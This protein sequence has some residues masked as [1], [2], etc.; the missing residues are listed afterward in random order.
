MSKLKFDDR[1]RV[2]A[3]DLHHLA[4]GRPDQTLEVFLDTQQGRALLTALAEAG[5][6]PNALSSW[7]GRD[8]DLYIHGSLAIAYAHWIGPTFFLSVVPHIKNTPRVGSNEC[9]TYYKAM[10]TVADRMGIKAQAM[11][12]VLKEVAKEERTLA[13]DYGAF[14]QEANAIESAIA[15]GALTLEAIAEV[16]GWSKAKTKNLVKRLRINL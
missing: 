16:T 4:G 13:K 7:D 15:G 12:E 6:V 1:C 3:A 11:N 14:Q 10:L 9:L 8:G 2:L 5:N